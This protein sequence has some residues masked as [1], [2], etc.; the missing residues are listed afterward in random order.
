MQI[1]AEPV[2]VFQ[3]PALPE[4]TLSAGPATPLTLRWIA[5]VRGRPLKDYP[6]I[7]CLQLGKLCAFCNDLSRAVFR[8]H[9][10]SHGREP[11]VKLPSLSPSRRRLQIARTVRMF[12]SKHGL[13]SWR[14]KVPG[15]CVILVLYVT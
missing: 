8:V 6:R 5:R 4:A 1:P 13:Y 12:S 14:D 11:G 3:L 9:G 15:A 2:S 10:I 7:H